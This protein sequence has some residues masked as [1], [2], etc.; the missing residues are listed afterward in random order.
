MIIAA[1]DTVEQAIAI[2]AKTALDNKIPFVAPNATE[3]EKGA[4]FALGVD[5]GQLG[6]ING[7]QAYSILVGGKKPGDIGVQGLNTP[8]I[9]I[10]LTTA[11]TL[12]LTIPQSLLLIQ[13]KDRRLISAVT[14]RH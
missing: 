4:L 13:R 11:R 1:D 5:Y 9:E 14:T 3:A 12:G 7:Q 8:I 2:V 10:N 6:Q